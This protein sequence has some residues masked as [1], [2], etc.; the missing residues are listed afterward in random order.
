MTQEK[1]DV[2]LIVNE[3]EIKNKELRNELHLLQDKQ[4]KVNFF[5]RRS[6][7]ITS[8]VNLRLKFFMIHNLYSIMVDRIFLMLFLII[9]RLLCMYYVTSPF[10]YNI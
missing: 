3:M 5:L 6:E 1:N 10:P 9:V 7:F 8:F 4:K 2:A